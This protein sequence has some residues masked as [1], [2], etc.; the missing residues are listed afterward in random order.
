VIDVGASYWLPIKLQAT[1]ESI[2]FFLRRTSVLEALSV[3][4]HVTWSR[5]SPR[6]TSSMCGAAGDAC[7]SVVLMD[8]VDSIMWILRSTTIQCST[9]PIA[10]TAFVDRNNIII[11]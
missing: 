7:L 1:G 5:A 11:V 9:S 10:G 3:S 4:G 8:S 2:A 6:H